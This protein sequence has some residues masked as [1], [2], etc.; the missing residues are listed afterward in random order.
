MNIFTILFYQPIYNLLIVLYQFLGDNLGLAIIAIAL[1]ARLILFPFTTK[2]IKMAEKNIEFSEKSKAIKKKHKG[3]KEKQQQELMKLQSEYLPGQLAGCLPMILQLIIFLQMYRVI[4]N[5]I[6]EGILGFSSVAYN[7]VPK[8][9]E[10]SVI[11]TD[12][13][14]IDLKTSASQL[15]LDEAKTWVY[16][17]LVLLVGLSQY[18]SMKVLSGLKSKRDDKKDEKKKDKKS[19][20]PDDFGEI[21]QQSTQQAMLLMPIMICF[22][23]YSLPAGLSIY[24]TV[25]SGF[26]IIQQ[27]VLHN[28]F[29]KKKEKENESSQSKTDK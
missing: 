25:Q 7:F 27:F 15:P 12:F 19:S 29:Y 1:V 13:F 9:A 2:Q 22:F 3:N 21:M 23:A 17:L 24:W 11:N 5:I 14:G 8:F 6:D 16:I 4:K 28:F 10:G 18:L 20:S 26:V